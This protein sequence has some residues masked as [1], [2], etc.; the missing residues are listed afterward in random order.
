MES[1]SRATRRT[2]RPGA[3]TSATNSGLLPCPSTS[4]TVSVICSA[5]R[6]GN[7]TRDATV[8]GHGH[9]ADGCVGP[10]LDRCDALTGRRRDVEPDAVHR[11]RSLG[12]HRDGLALTATEVAEGPRRR[13]VAVEGVLRGR[14]GIQSETRAHLA[15]VH[16]AADDPEHRL[17]LRLEEGDA[18]A[19]ILI[20]RDEGP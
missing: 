15:S 6:P 12:A 18:G 10:D 1:G 7:R 5:V 13:R 16:I 20:G 17:L 14:A 3:A 2:P 11:H 9:L 8:G 19:G 4:V